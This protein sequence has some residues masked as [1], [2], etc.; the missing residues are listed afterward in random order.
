MSAPLKKV[1]GILGNH[2][3]AY[4]TERELDW[5]FED[6]GYEVLRFQEN[7]TSTDEILQRMSVA[8]AELLVYI[9]THGWN[10]PGSFSVE[11]LIKTLRGRDIKTCSF[12]L[13][14]Y[15]GL[16]VA[17]GREDR[18]GTHP[19]FKTDYVFTADGGNQEKFKARGVNHFWLPPGVVARDCFIGLKQNYLACDVAFVGQKFYHPEYPFRG[20]LIDWLKSVYV[21]RFR[22]FPEGP[23]PIRQAELNDLYASA[24][25][26]V[27]DSCFA[28]SPYYWSDRV[29]ETIGRGGFLIHPKTEGLDIPGMAIFDAGNYGQLKATIDYWLAHEDR[30]EHWRTIAHEHVKKNDTYTN[31]VKTMLETMGL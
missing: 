14:R 15:W 2:S 29:P 17:D 12:H 3:V 10:T 30:R 24:K 11:E 26:V 16:N 13:D 7:Q 31:R 4:C 20:N 5:T 21:G 19:F 27:G 18:V 23:G 9:H 25:V 1:V 22:H 28:G 6:L 8:R